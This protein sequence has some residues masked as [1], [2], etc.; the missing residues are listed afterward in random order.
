MDAVHRYVI[1]AFFDAIDGVIGDAS[2]HVAQV[3]P[4]AVLSLPNI[5]ELIQD[6]EI[7]ISTLRPIGCVAAAAD[8]DCTHAMLV[9]RRD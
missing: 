9:R 6:G 3:D 8:Q 4:C 1:A 7:T 2:Q 5:A